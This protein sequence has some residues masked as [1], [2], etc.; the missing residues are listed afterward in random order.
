MLTNKDLLFASLMGTANIK[1][2]E[3]TQLVQNELSKHVLPPIPFLPFPKEDGITGQ[4]ASPAFL[5]NQTD[6]PIPED[7][8]FFPLSFSLT[9]NGQKWLFPYEPMITISS[10]NTVIKRNV[11]KQGNTLIGTIKERWNRKDF[12]ITVTG[13]LMGGLIKG[14]VEDCFPR[15]QM[16][17]LFEFLKYNKEFYI[18]CAPLEILGITKVVVEDYTFPFTKGEN[19][20]AYDLKITSDD[21]YN[22]LV[23]EENK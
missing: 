17:R 1:M 19:V 5:V 12:D 21:F 22:L 2:Y 20:Q 9:E 8:Q 11:A 18:Y 10:G 7:Q 14:K 23:I 3:R 4:T 15:E 6:L 13:V 16:Q